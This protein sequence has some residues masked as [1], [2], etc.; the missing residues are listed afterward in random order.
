MRV[1][2]EWFWCDVN[3]VI[4]ALCSKSSISLENMS[5]TRWPGLKKESFDAQM[6][7]KCTSKE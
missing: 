4:G 2:P 7:Q 3:T 1:T 5:A 6:V